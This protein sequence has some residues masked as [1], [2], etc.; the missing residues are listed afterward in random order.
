[1]WIDIF[2]IEAGAFI[3]LPVDITPRKVEDYEL[4]AIIWHVQSLGSGRLSSKQGLDLYVK[5]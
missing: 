4:R 5:A 1:M 2:P 3:P